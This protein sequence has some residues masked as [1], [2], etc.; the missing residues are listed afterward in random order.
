MAK[1]QALAEINK[2]QYKAEPERL[3]A[4][5][6]SRQEIEKRNIEI[7]AEAEA[8]RTR[9]EAK[10][11][12]D[13]ILMKYEAE[14][15]GTRK[16]LD[17]KAEG[18]NQMVKSCDGDAKAAATFLMIEKLEKIVEKQVEAVKN[19]KIDK[20][21]VWDTGGNGSGGNTTSNFLSGMIK[22]LPPLHDG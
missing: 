16:V 21:T 5:S 13:A 20:I 12:A 19:L 10:G 4:E 7:A 22:S 8:E 18:Y 14:A 6:V 11:E 9:R 2:A 1:R 17:A 15:Q 3:N